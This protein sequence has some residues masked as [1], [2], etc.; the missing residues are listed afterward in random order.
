MKLHPS[1]QTKETTR[2]FCQ[3]YKYK[4]VLKTR[5]A[6]W[7]RGNSLDNVKVQLAEPKIMGKMLTA[8]EQNYV[9]KLC[10]ELKKLTDYIL[11]VESPLISVYTNNLTIVEKLAK[12]SH[13]NVKYVSAPLAGSENLLEDKK[14]IV[15]RLDYA[16]KVTMGRTRQNYTDFL[17]WCEGKDKVRLP[18]RAKSQLAK[19]HSW[20]G[21]YFYVKDEKCL[22]MV[23]MFVGS[24]IQT[25][26]SVVKS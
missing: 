20:G 11:R 15:K 3:K 22:T 17:T 10:L 26:E 4:I 24:D 9:L 23:K 19:E 14:I 16:F 21:Y 8:I 12:V 1:I 6:G 25:V 13:E 5:A 7:F 18:K 2:L